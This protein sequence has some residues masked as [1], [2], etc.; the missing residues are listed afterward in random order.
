MTQEQQIGRIFPSS[1]EAA[2]AAEGLRELVRTLAAGVTVQDP[3]GRLI[4]ANPAAEELYGTPLAQMRGRAPWTIWALANEDGSELA[5]SERPAVRALRTRRPVRDQVLRLTRPDGTL[6]WIRITAVPVF[7][8]DGRPLQV[9]SSLVDVTERKLAE[10]ALRGSEARKGAILAS[11]MDCVV[12]VDHEGRIIDFNPAAETTFGYR[13]DQVIGQP[14][15]DT[16]IPPEFRPPHLRGFARYIESGGPSRMVGQRVEVTA[17]R[18][19]GSRFPAEV[20]ITAFDLNG[21]SAFTCFLRDIT[22][23][24]EAEKERQH[25]AR[26]EKLRALGQ[27]AGGVAHDLNQSLGIIAGYCDV[28][29]QALD[30]ASVDLPEVRETLGMVAQAAMDGG[31]T[32]KRLLMFAR[33]QEQGERQRLD[34]GALLAEVARLTA[35]RWRDAAQVEGRPIQVEV[36]VEGDLAVD[37][38]P[39]NLR[40]AFTNL[41]LNAVDAMPRGGLVTLSAR[42]VDPSPSSGQ[43]AEIEVSVADNGAGM[44]PEVQARV[45]EPF[46]STKG[47]KGTG[48]GLAMV[49]GVVEQHG[50]RI[51]LESEVGRG[52]TFRMFL[53]AAGLLAAERQPTGAAGQRRVRR[54]L[55]VDDEPSL[56]QL[57]PRLLGQDGHYVAVAASGEEALAYLEREA[58]VGRPFDLVISDLGMGPGMNG[59]DLADQ[60]RRRFPAVCFTLAT[61]WGEQI[62]PETARERG[63]QAVLSKPYRLR[64]LKRLVAET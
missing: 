54:I 40:A 62:D 22:E 61:G 42:R 32:V 59:W 8:A 15:A 20:S 13:R 26:S 24:K 38:W 23:R 4:A 56:R 47:E 17:M 1:F 19:D 34:L 31:E 64:D 36:R 52:T 16:L 2:I 44:P 30:R 48:L 12:T 49:Y 33:A 46:F 35:P 51:A 28:V 57:I 53:P 21:L 11:A 25:L 7:D 14:L 10:E 43:A 6:R 5:H 18:A 45:F 29:T 39:A 58:A 50:G 37:G 63:V 60:V 55:A 9:V 27:L 41:V 3:A